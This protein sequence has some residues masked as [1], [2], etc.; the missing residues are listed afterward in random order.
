MNKIVSETINAVASVT[1]L[2]KHSEQGGGVGTDTFRL[3]VPPAPTNIK[4]GELQ[5]VR[6]VVDRGGSFKQVLKLA[7][8]TTQGLSL[9]PADAT[10][11]P[12]DKGEVK[13]RIRA[14]TDAPIGNHT[15]RVMGTPEQGE[16]ANTDFEIVVSA[17]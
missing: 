9:E 6:L 13:L 14:A 12:G 11:A 8:R 7:A 5:T 2:T 3:G 4:Q 16:V 17:R 15:I 1:G 10:L